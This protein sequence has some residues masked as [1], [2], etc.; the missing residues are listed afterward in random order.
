MGPFKLVPCDIIERDSP[1]S[2]NAKIPFK[3]KP[4]PITYAK[5]VTMRIKLGIFFA[6][7][8]SISSA[9]KVSC[10]NAPLAVNNKLKPANTEDNILAAC[11]LKKHDTTFFIMSQCSHKTMK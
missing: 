4:I 1:Y 10:A 3:I 8:A 9:E 6:K 5:A 11:F 2:F 7:L